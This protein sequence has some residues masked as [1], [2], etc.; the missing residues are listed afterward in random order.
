MINIATFSVFFAIYSI[1]SLMVQAPL[2][3]GNAVC[4]V[5][6]ISDVTQAIVA[7]AFVNGI[8]Y[9]F[10]TWII[11]YIGSSWIKRKLQKQED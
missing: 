6:Q 2:F 7:N 4:D 8:F 1:S 5:L 10:A 9:G 3:P 11:Y